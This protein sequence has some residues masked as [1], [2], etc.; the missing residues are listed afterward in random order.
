MR[1]DAI[2]L[3]IWTAT[4][5]ACASELAERQPGY[6]RRKDPTHPDAP[7][8][9]FRA[10]P[11]YAPDPLLPSPAKASVPAVYTCPMHPAV[12]QATPG[13]CP[14]CGMKLVPVLKEQP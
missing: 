3:A 14:Y 10:P 12:R 1:M 8:A 13:A 4:L 2:A 7:E 9:P 6:D 5:T 11:A